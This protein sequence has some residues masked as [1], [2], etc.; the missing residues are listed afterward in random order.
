MQSGKGHV[1]IVKIPESTI[2]HLMGN[3]REIINNI[4]E[5]HAVLTFLQMKE[6]SWQKNAAWSSD[7]AW[8]LD[9]ALAVKHVPLSNVGLRVSIHLGT[10]TKLCE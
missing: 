6:D 3:A 4:E 10:S 1:E 5:T 8:H 9:Q 7:A 2:K